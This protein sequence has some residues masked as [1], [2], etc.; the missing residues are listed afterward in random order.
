MHL[1][2][3]PEFQEKKLPE[4]AKVGGRSRQAQLIKKQF[5]LKAGLRE[6][7]DDPL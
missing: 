3:V 7:P 5:L 2:P 1:I 4:G 6:G